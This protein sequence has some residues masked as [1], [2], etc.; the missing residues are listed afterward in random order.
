MAFASI[1]TRKGK[2]HLTGAKKGNRGAE[3]QQ[4][5]LGGDSDWGV[6][7]EKS[8]LRIGQSPWFP[9]VP[10]RNPYRLQPKKDACERKKHQQTRKAT[11]W[12]RFGYNI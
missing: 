9:G 1:R 6:A 3:E 10:G 2:K 5:Q 7:V 4:R 8:L 11:R 12:K